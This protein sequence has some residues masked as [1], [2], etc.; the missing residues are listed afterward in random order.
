[1]SNGYQANGSGL[2][3]RGSVRQD[4]GGRGGFRGRG[5]SSYNAAQPMQNAGEGGTFNVLFKN[6]I[7]EGEQLISNS[8]SF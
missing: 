1:M 7:V 2:A 5:A 8:W 6:T 4:R 3:G